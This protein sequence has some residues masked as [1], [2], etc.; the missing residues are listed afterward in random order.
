MH[1]TP[2]ENCHVENGILGKDFN[3]GVI[4][5]FFHAFTPLSRTSIFVNY[6]PYFIGGFST[7][8]IIF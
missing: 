6:I 8:Y 4:G 2:L 5:S 1:Y 3:L 7:N